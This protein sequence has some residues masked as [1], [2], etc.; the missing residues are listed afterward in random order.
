MQDSISV[1]ILN[2]EGTVF[3]GEV[4]A[5]SSINEMGPF[6]VLPLHSNFISIIKDKVVVYLKS[7][8]SKEFKVD[9][10]ILKAAENKIQ[11][12]LGIETLADLSEA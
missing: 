3:D 11:V 9:S 6:D 8:G 7:G 4:K 1:S 5:L 12:F 2:S 10:G